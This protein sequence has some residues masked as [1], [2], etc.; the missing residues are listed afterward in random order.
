MW[1]GEWSW[2]RFFVLVDYEM[3]RKVARVL[4]CSFLHREKIFLKK[5]KSFLNFWLTMIV[6]CGP[7]M[8]SRRKLSGDPPE[9]L[10]GGSPGG[11]RIFW[12]KSLANPDKIFKKIFFLHFFGNFV[13]IC[14]WFS[15]KIRR[16][17]AGSLRG[18]SGRFIS[19][20]QGLIVNSKFLWIVYILGIKFKSTV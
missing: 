4:K 15:Q 2:E 7:A 1:R 5:M 11:L 12:L 20:K 18:V 9:T 17:P 13:C 14:Q 10:R 6:P 16:P 8:L 3:H 19:V